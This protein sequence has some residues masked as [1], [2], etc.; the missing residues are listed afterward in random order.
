MS[1]L[2]PFAP[3]IRLPL[4]KGWWVLTVCVLV[5][6]C[7]AIP[8]GP[9]WGAPPYIRV[10]STA[11][12]NLADGE[13]TLREAI[14]IVN[15]GTGGDGVRTGLGRALNPGEAALITGGTIGAIGRAPASYFP[16]FPGAPSFPS[17]M[18][19]SCLRC[20]R[21]PNLPNNESLPPILT[22]GVVVDGTSSAGTP[23]TIDRSGVT[24]AIN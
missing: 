13:I 12:T 7:G 2:F 22:S 23:I 5:G 9:A 16:T 18:V 4:T 11:D 14:L 6:V 1:N 10:N 8:G 21:R 3:N 20:P 19:R 24:C 15:G 17:Q